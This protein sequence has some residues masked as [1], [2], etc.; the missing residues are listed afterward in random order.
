MATNPQ[1]ATSVVLA[2]QE[3]HNRISDLEE[4]VFGPAEEAPREVADKV[5]TQGR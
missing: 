2:F 1:T 3:L 4:R 5:D